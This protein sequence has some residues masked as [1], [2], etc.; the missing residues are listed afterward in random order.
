MNQKIVAALIV[1]IIAA[2]IVSTVVGLTYLA[3]SS[4]GYVNSVAS[5]TANP[6]TI[7]WGTINSGDTTP[8]TRN[9]QIQNTGEQATK[10]LHLSAS[11]TVGNITWTGES[12]TI[13][14][15][16]TVTYTFTLTPSA[17]PTA[18]AFNVEISI[19]D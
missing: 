5:L 14:A 12:Q 16:A 1:V 15:G 7:D 10:P 9:I 17:S 11:T 19:T 2:A 4:S 18:G 3:I 13:G 8:I 6:T